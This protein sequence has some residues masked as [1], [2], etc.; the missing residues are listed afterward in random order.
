MTTHAHTRA[1]WAAGLDAKQKLQAIAATDLGGVAEDYDVSD[2]RVYRKGNRSLGMGFARAAQRAIDLGETFDGHA[3]PEDI[4]EMTVRSATALAGQGLIGVAKD[5]FDTGGRIQSS[6]AVAA[7]RIIVG[8]R[9]AK[10]FALNAETGEPGY[11]LSA[12]VQSVRKLPFGDMDK[13][14]EEALEIEKKRKP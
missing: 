10:L 12:D 4:N 3:L 14:I 8:S 11:N 7:G 2:G 9:A 13:W 5:N 6:P 1:N